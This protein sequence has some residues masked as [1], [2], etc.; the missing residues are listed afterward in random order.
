MPGPLGSGLDNDRPLTGPWSDYQNTAPSKPETKSYADFNGDWKSYLEYMA[1]Q[2]DAASLDKLVNYMM[3][4]QSNQIARDWTAS[5]ED[6]QY[7]RL[8]ADL[9]AAGI[10]PY[11]LMQSGAS[12]ISSSSSGSSYNNTAYGSAASLK[13]TARHNKE[14][15]QR[16]WLKALV[17]IIPMVLAVAIAAI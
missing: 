16:D 9:K 11:I 15:E 4:E 5:R 14:T 17:S 10:N 8:V 7:Q 3:T 13:E 12:P 6:T 2:G 1:N